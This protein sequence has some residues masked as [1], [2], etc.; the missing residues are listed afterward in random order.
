MRRMSKQGELA[1]SDPVYIFTIFESGNLVVGITSEG[2]M[3]FG[4]GY[5]P[6]Q[7]AKLF[8]EAITERNPLNLK[9]QRLE[10]DKKELEI[11]NK[12]LN[13]EVNKLMRE[14]SFERMKKRDDKT[15]S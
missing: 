6:E 5:K 14:L 10:Q 3:S 1:K 13:D 8:W 12:K 2:K 11:I 15:Y 7:A 9:V 4:P